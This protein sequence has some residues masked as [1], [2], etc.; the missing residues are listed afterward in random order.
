MMTSFIIKNKLESSTSLDSPFWIIQMYA[1]KTY[2][3]PIL[4]KLVLYR[5]LYQ[6]A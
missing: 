3:K 1:I 4:I 5:K 6:D 2:V